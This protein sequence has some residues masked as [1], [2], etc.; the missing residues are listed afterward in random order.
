MPKID[1]RKLNEEIKKNNLTGAYFLFGSEQYLLMKYLE[2][3]LKRAVPD[4][5][6]FNLQRFEAEKGQ[7]DWGAVE[8]AVQNLPMMALRKVVV[9]HNLNPDQLSTEEMKRLQKLV[10]ELPD[11]TIFVLYITGFELPV[12]SSRKVQNFLKFM[13][14][15]G[16]VV[17]FLPLSK[18]DLSRYLVS[19]A[20]KSGCVLS[21]EVAGRM[22][23]DCGADLTTL[24]SNLE[25]VISYTGQ[26]EITIKTVEE[27]TEKT[28]DATAFDLANAVL[29]GNLDTALRAVAELKAQR[30]EPIMIAGAVNSA[31]VD[32]YR[33]KCALAAGKTAAD[34]TA[35]FGYN[36]RIRFRVDNAF[37]SAG[38][39][40]L[41]TLRRGMRLLKKLD[42]QLKSSRSEPYELLETTLVQIQA[43]K[44]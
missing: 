22:V 28:M 7:I 13:E 15:N 31:F 39:M 24:L 23:E 9:L 6:A 44:E 5:S 40:E 33:A 10:E 16:T 26:G 36:P 42:S 8:D 34:M 4:M 29:R 41:E 38:R 17:D 25:K 20:A 2:K 3:L 12:K 11:S 43:G 37:R 21:T 35:D 1:F 19:E 30:V 32:L 18:N 14:K 27:L